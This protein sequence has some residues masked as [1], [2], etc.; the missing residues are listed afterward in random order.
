MNGNS[1]CWTRSGSAARPKCVVVGSPVVVLRAPV[2]ESVHFF[3]SRI[4]E[5]L[6]SDERFSGVGGTEDGGR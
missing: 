4:E 1:P 3:S 5:L 2:N 6:S